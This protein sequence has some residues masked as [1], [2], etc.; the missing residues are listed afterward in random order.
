MRI[1]NPMEYGYHRT[2]VIDGLYTTFKNALSHLIPLYDDSSFSPADEVVLEV[3]E[4]LGEEFGLNAYL[5]R[6][7]DGNL[8]SNLGINLAGRKATINGYDE[9]VIVK[10]DSAVGGDVLYISGVSDT[11]KN[12]DPARIITVNNTESIFFET[13]VFDF[14]TNY[15]VSRKTSK[16][17]GIIVKLTIRVQDDPKKKRLDYITGYIKDLIYAYFNNG[18]IPIQSTTSMDILGYTHLASGIITEDVETSDVIQERTISIPL[19]YSNTYN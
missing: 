15:A 13:D 14:P 7:E 19:G 4:V 18:R 3:H 9:V 12:A 2:V 6:L 10:N 5:V 8:L 11:V 1:T 16:M 17:N